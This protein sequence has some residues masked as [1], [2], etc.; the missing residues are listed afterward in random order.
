MGTP[1]FSCNYTFI[2]SDIL[3]P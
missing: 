3:L 2:V 1:N